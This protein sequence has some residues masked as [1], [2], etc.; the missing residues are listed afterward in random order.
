MIKNHKEKLIE[1]A[2]RADKFLEDVMPQVGG[3]CIQDFENLNELC[4]LVSEIK[5]MTEGK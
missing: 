4:C 2:H 5:S 1:L 3:L